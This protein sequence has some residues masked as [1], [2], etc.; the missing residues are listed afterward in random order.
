MIDFLLLATPITI[1]GA[2]IVCQVKSLLGLW[3]EKTDNTTSK[4]KDAK[5]SLREVLSN[6]LDES[7]KVDLALLKELLRQAELKVQD[8]DL[9]KQRIDNRAYQM[10]GVSMAIITYFANKFFGVD[11]QSTAT[12]IFIGFT[13]S[14]YLLLIIELFFILIP[15]NYAGSGNRP[16]R[17]VDILS[18]DTNTENNTLP[19]VLILSLKSYDEGLEKSV[20]SNNNRLKILERVLWFA[21]LY[22]TILLI[23][24]VHSGMKTFLT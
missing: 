21:I 5:T 1:C 8:E 24:V 7:K 14:C 17:W 6:L 10:I 12:I 3:K 15:Q 2:Y 16:S 23:C 9:R 19:K 11:V 13:I 4:L 18:Y 20:E 22:S